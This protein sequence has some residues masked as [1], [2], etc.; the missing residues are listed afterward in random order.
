[1]TEKVVATVEPKNTRG[2]TPGPKNRPWDKPNVELALDVR[3]DEKIVLFADPSSE[4]EY[5]ESWLRPRSMHDAGL[6]PF[7]VVIFD[8]TDITKK[9]LMSCAASDVRMIGI[10]PIDV[11]HEKYVR[12]MITSLYPWT[13]VYEASTT[14][15]K[16]LMLCP[17]GA[18]YD[19]DRIDD[20]YPRA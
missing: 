20:S 14:F 12:R 17:R 8:R 7:T 3:S 9:Q 11:D 19:R 5:P 10:C 4:Y 13:Q 15:G 18:P 6:D 1:M 2:S 16:V